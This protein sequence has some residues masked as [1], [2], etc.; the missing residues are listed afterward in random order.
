MRTLSQFSAQPR[1]Q[2]GGGTHD[3]AQLQKLQHQKRNKSDKGCVCYISSIIT[4]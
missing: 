4:Y 3:C 2:K 1:F